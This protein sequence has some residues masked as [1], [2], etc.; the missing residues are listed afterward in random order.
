MSKKSTIL[1]FK[2][3]SE[4]VTETPIATLKTQTCAIRQLKLRI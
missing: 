4:I 1:S 2:F 3:K